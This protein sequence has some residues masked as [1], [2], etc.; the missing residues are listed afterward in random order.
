MR[1]NLVV[2]LP[3]NINRTA[4]VTKIR[5][6]VLIEAG[7]TE[8]AVKAFN[9]CVLCRLTGLN[10]MEPYAG[11]LCP[12]KHGLAG[13]FAAVIADQS[14]RQP[15]GRGQ[16]VQESDDR[17]AGDRGVGKLPDALSAVVIHNIQH[18]EASSVRQLIG[19]EIQ[20]PALIGGRGYGERNPRSHQMLALASPDLQPQLA[21]KSVDPFA[22]DH[23]TFCLEQAV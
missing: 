3:R 6:P 2:M 23:F 21:V 13:T 14:P 18:P 11:A 10:E 9:E 17:G 8:F 22:V 7:V 15:A 12:Q 1:P 19:D 20:R 4:S 5:E 16:I